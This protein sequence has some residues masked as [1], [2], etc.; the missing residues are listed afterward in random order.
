MFGVYSGDVLF[1]PGEKAITVF[2]DRAQET[3]SVTLAA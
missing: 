3:R 1:G 2:G